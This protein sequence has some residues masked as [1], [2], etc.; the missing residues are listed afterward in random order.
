M[1]DKACFLTLTVDDEHM[2]WSSGSGEQTLN[3]DEVQKFFKRLR[4]NTGLQFRYI[5]C[6]EYGEHTYRP[7]YHVLLYGLDFKEDRFFW[8][9]GKRGDPYYIS[10]FL[11]KQWKQGQC[12]IGDVNFLT[13]AYVGRYVTK[14]LKGEQG[15]I[16][17]EHKVAPFIHASN[18][19][20]IGAT[21]FE[22]Y[23]SDIYPHDECIVNYNGNMR[24]IK[25]PRYYD[26]LLE[27]S[28]PEMYNFVKEERSKKA[29]KYTEEIYN[30]RLFFKELYKQQIVDETLRRD[31]E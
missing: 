12:C 4:K 28:D 19:P 16:E 23:H 26:K 3:Y 21:W 5:C 15:R 30:D 22:K 24:K 31:L 2:Y 27:K 8:K 6:G 20:G 13:C 29:D 25:P 9:F 1:S 7:H 11:D 17:Y 14:K 10:R 18:K